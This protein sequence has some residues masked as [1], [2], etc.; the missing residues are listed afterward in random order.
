MQT[1]KPRCCFY[2]MLG[3]GYWILE[4][5]LLI[6][7]IA[8]KGS[9]GAQGWLVILEKVTLHIDL[10]KKKTTKLSLVTVIKF[11]S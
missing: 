10:Y 7:W 11:V 6:H 1:H 2:V 3:I 5:K 4:K 9:L 8:C